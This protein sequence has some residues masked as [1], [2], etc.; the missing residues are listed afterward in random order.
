MEFAFELCRG[1]V[2]LA[3]VRAHLVAV[4]ALGFYQDVG[5]LHLAEV[6]APSVDGRV[7]DF[8]FLR[9]L[10]HCRAIRLAQDRDHLLFRESTLLHG[11]L[12]R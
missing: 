10:G 9:C 12:F 6:F 7:T 2:L 4:I 5:R 8:V 1:Q 3:T 11:L